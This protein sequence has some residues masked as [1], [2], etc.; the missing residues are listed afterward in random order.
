MSS[1]D[2]LRNVHR[3][4]ILTCGSTV[5]LLMAGALVTSNDA[6]DSVPDWPLAYGKIIPPFV[7]G[8]RYEFTHRVVAGLVAILTLALALW[9]ARSERRPWVRRLGWTVL[10]LVLTQ[11]LLGAF[12][13]LERHAALSA[14]AHAILAQIF[15]AALVS[16]ALFT[17]SWWQFEVPLLDD[18]GSPCV[19]SLAAS[20]TAVI[21]GQLV[22]GAA[23]RHGAFGIVP[24]IVGAGV[25]ALAVIWTGRAAKKRFARIPS[26]RRSVV[27]LHATFGTQ[28]LLGGAAYWAILASREAPQPS[29]AYVALSVAHVLVGALTLAASVILT[30]V[31]FRL[32]RR[33]PARAHTHAQ[34]EVLTR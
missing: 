2:N 22:L 7:G 20:T 8:I 18:P 30:L 24:H 15:F 14:T 5:L 21:F 6:A 28:I 12:R 1:T 17:S 29:L 11:A 34:S 27:W 25:V 23:F 19:S 3:F 26:I 33:E 13:V 16:L 10:A 4:V 31:C 32:I 9:L